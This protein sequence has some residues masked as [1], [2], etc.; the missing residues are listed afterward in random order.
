MG[1]VT[2]EETINWLIHGDMKHALKTYQGLHISMNAQLTYETVVLYYYMLFQIKSSI[3]QY[4]KEIS[5]VGE[6]SLLSANSV[7]VS[8]PNRK[9]VRES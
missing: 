4:I 7:F 6:V 5:T 2:Q 3:A 8:I 9:R 1:N